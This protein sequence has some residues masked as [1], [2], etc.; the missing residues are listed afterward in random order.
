MHLEERCQL[1]GGELFL[2][3]QQRLALALGKTILC[4][5]PKLSSAPL[6]TLRSTSS[7]GQLFATHVGGQ[8]SEGSFDDSPLAAETEARSPETMASADCLKEVSA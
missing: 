2:L 8:P 7:E 5:R 6:G 1:G 4:C 3:P